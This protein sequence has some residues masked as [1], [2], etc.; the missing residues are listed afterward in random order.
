[1]EATL[2]RNVLVDCLKL[3]NTAISSLYL[4]Q[5]DRCVIFKDDHIYTSNGHSACVVWFKTGL[6]CAVDA[7][8]LYGVVN[9]T[10]ADTLNVTLGDESLVVSEENFKATLALVSLDQE[11]KLPE[12]AKTRGKIG[13]TE[14][15]LSFA[16]AIAEVK[17]FA[18]IDGRFP[19]RRGVRLEFGKKLVTCCACRGQFAVRLATDCV[20]GELSG[21]S[22]IVSQESVSMLVDGFKMYES[23]ASVGVD[24]SSIVF[25]FA[26]V[27][28]EDKRLPECTLVCTQPEIDSTNR[29]ERLDYA[30][31]FVEMLSANEIKDADYFPAP[32]GFEEAITRCQLVKDNTDATSGARIRT[33]GS[34]MFISGKGAQG[35]ILTR[36]PVPTGVRPISTEIEPSRLGRIVSMSDRLALG[37]SDVMSFLGPRFKGI[38]FYYDSAVE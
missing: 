23:P 12:L 18:D 30:A 26:R 9:S 14:M 24:G 5:I 6:T 2:N 19:N 33:K 10:S 22:A 3:L 4:R 37:K 32:K 15:P 1:M 8:A 17:D 20:C 11:G 35:K 34:T 27:K 7:Q 13:T 28:T 16:D 31:M 36:L 21:T 29:Q 25:R 38:M